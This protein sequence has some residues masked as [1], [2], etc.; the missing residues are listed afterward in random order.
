MIVVMKAQFSTRAIL[1]ATAFIAVACGAWVAYRHNYLQQPLWEPPLPLPLV[2]TAPLWIPFVFLAYAIGRRTLT[3]RFVVAFAL[4]E[5]AA[6][7]FKW[8]TCDWMYALP[9]P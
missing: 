6:V 4:I 3:A 9:N 5:L 8:S 7:F 2:I 1:L